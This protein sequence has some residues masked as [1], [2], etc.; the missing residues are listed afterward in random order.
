ML[1][2]P[3][4]RALLTR[5]SLAGAGAVLVYIFSRPGLM[6]PQRIG[7]MLLLLSIAFGCQMQALLLAMQAAM[8][9]GA[10]ARVPSFRSF[11]R[12]LGGAVGLAARGAIKHITW[13]KQLDAHLIDQIPND[14]IEAFEHHPLAVAKALPDLPA[15]ALLRPAKLPSRSRRCQTGGYEKDQRVCEC[16]VPSYSCDV[17]P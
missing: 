13:P 7:I 2:G 8:P 1:Q 12:N 9:Q 11:C 14:I 15:V 16:L 17:M 3:A 5:D 10:V 4:P 6:V